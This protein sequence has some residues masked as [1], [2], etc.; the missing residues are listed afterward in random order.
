MLYT[1][2]SVLRYYV[3]FSQIQSHIVQTTGLICVFLLTRQLF[4]LIG[5]KIIINY[6]QFPPFSTLLK[7]AVKQL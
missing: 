5:N 3:R 2:K 4:F 7:V 6:V 1:E